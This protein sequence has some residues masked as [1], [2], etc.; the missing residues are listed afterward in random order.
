[1]E[2]GPHDQLILNPM[3]HLITRSF[4]VVCNFS[5]AHRDLHTHGVDRTPS[6]WPLH[7]AAAG[8]HATYIVAIIDAD[9]RLTTFTFRR[10]SAC[11]ELFKH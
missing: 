8:A 6:L 11:D 4:V 1:M 9:F 5:C 7:Q 2:A 10:S 3:D